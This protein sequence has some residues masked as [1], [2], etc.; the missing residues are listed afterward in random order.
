MYKM[1]DS[2]INCQVYNKSYHFTLTMP[3]AS[4]NKGLFVSIAGNDTRLYSYALIM[5]SKQDSIFD[6]VLLA[7]YECFFRLFICIC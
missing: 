3:S 1:I 5:F 2:R 6:N 4:E 7:K